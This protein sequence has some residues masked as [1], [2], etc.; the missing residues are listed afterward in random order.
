MEM[1]ELALPEED[2]NLQEFFPKTIRYDLQSLIEHRVKLILKENTTFNGGEIKVVNT[3]IML[4]GKLKGNKLSMF[5][6]PAEN[7]RLDFQS[8]G[9]ISSNYKGRVLV[10]LAN[11]S[12]KIIKLQSGTPVGYIVL[13]PYSL[14]K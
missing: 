7:M 6:I 9:Y 13:T 1:S 14:E 10:K 2:Y 11:Y 4:N 12:G 8:G 5:L 3:C